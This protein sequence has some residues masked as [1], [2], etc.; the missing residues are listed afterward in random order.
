MR[1]L[2]SGAAGRGLT[3]P[4][5]SLVPSAEL[6][7]NLTLYNE[8]TKRQEADILVKAAL[9]AETTRQKVDGIRANTSLLV[10]AADAKIQRIESESAADV[11][12]LVQAAEADAEAIR[13]NAIAN[14]FEQFTTEIGF[15]PTVRAC[16]AAPRGARTRLTAAAWPPPART[17][18]RWSGPT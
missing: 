13:A 18:T 11:E 12:R 17:S 10:A 7:S 5:A 14:I 3:A 1:R 2:R 8:I 16:S 15:T 9:I 6:T 4:R